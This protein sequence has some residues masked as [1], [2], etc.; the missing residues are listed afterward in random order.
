MVL[1]GAGWQRMAPGGVIWG[2]LAPGGARWSRVALGGARSRQEALGGAEW[3]RVVPHYLGGTMWCGLVPGGTGL[4][5]QGVTLLEGGAARVGDTEEEGGTIGG[6]RHQ[7]VLPLG[8]GP[9]CGCATG[10]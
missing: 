5:N 8:D 4:C 2:W 10:G 1:V 6:W 7:G 9:A 3:C